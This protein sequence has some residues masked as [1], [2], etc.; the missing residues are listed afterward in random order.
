MRKPSRW[1]ARILTTLGVVAPLALALT[2]A[3][4]RGGSGRE[5]PKVLHADGG[6]YYACGGVMW[7]SNHDTYYARGSR[8]HEVV[9]VDAA[10]VQRGLHQVHSMAV[11]DL[12]ADAPECRVAA[13]AAAP[14]PSAAPG[15]SAETEAERPK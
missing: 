10:G 8:S 12:R 1:A 7:T 9:Y 13:N 11:T 5:E 14:S 15:M 6:P 3:L 4:F 2:V